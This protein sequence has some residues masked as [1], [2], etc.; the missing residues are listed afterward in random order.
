MGLIQ[1][2][3]KNIEIAIQAH[4]NAI[5]LDSQLLDAYKELGYLCGISHRYEA[6][7]VNY[8]KYLATEQGDAYLYMSL[9]VCYKQL[10]RREKAIEVYRLGIKYYPEFIE[11]Y[12]RLSL[13]LQELD[14]IEEA[15]ETVDRSVESFPENI[16][17]KIE[18]F[19]ILP[20]VR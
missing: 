9:A 15:I 6:A 4:Q 2:Q 8:E 7:I 12:L 20:I 13:N 19:R 18:Q 1:E 10:D 5:G 17:L 3:L 11:F 14:R 16:A